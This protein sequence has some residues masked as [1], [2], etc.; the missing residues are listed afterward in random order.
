MKLHRITR[1]EGYAIRRH[2]MVQTG[3]MT[4]GEYDRAERQADRI[5]NEILSNFSFRHPESEVW[6]NRRKP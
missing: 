4:P 2:L 1:G 6:D 5:I 3:R